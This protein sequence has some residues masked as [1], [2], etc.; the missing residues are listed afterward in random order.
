MLPS[1]TSPA[2]PQ[3]SINTIWHLF[4]KLSNHPL[5]ALNSIFPSFLVS[6][7]HVPV[8]LFQILENVYGSCVQITPP[9]SQCCIHF[10]FFILPVSLNHYYNSAIGFLLLTWLLMSYTSSFPSVKLCHDF[11]YLCVSPASVT[12][13]FMLKSST[14][15]L[16]GDHGNN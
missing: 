14:T 11:F 12:F 13:T 1:Q 10:Q 9:Q 15:L 8:P 16:F 3:T 6:S 5:D 4:L 7:L 2:L